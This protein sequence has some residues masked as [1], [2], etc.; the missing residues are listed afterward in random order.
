MLDEVPVHGLGLGPGLADRL[1]E[2]DCL[3]NEGDG[4]HDVAEGEVASCMGVRS[5]WMPRATDTVAPATNRPIAANSDQTYASRPYPNGCARS[6]ARRD[7][8]LAI[9]RKTSLPASAQECAA[10]A[11]SDADPVSAAATDFAA[12]MSTL[13]PKATSTVV[14]LSDPAGPP[15]PGTD[16]SRSCEPPAALSGKQAPALL[17]IP[18]RAISQC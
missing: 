14:T 5:S 16:L 13:T 18:S 11:T 3:E 12:A 9:I 4:Q 15:D 1:Q 8:R 17:A 2:G 7:R 6:G 10:S